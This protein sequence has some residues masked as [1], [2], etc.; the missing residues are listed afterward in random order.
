MNRELYGAIWKDD[1]AWMESMKGAKWDRLLH[2]AGAKWGNQ[3]KKVKENIPIMMHMM[4]AESEL[5]NAPFFR[6]SGKDKYAV[7]ISLLGTQSIAWNWIGNQNPSFAKDLDTCPKRYPGIVWTIEETT[8]SKGADKNCL[9]CYVK[10]YGTKPVWEKQGVGI[11]V[12]VINGRVFTTEVEHDLVQVRLVSWDATSGQDYQVHYEEKNK[13]YSLELH[14]C[15]CNI[16]YVK[17]Y[18]GPKQDLF[19]ISF[20]HKNKVCLNV[21]GGITLES[22]RFIIGDKENFLFTWE[23]ATGWRAS[24]ALIQSYQLPALKRCDNPESLLCQRGIFVTR[25]RGERTIWR[26]YK[27]KPAVFLWKGYANVTLDPWGGPWVRLQI[28]GQ[29]ALWWNSEIDERPHSGM[30]FTHQISSHQTKRGVPMVLASPITRKVKGLLI[31]GYGAYGMP[32]HFS[33]DRWAPLLHEGWAIAFGLWRG[34]GDHSPEWEDA[35]RRHGREDVL[36]DSE[37]VVRLARMITG[38]SAAKTALYGRSA[39]GLWVGGLVARYRDG[40]LFGHAY[41]E[42]PYLDVLQT[43]TNPALPLTNIEADEFGLPSQRI[44]DF[45]SILRWSPMEM[46]LQGARKPVVQ[47]IVRTGLNDKHVFAYEAAKWY[48]RCGAN[49][50]LAIEGNQGHFVSGLVGL[51]QKAEDLAVLLDWV[52]QAKA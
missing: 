10:E 48:A 22:R 16:G 46:L 47:Q 14:R 12:A 38:V 52:S 45:A 49:C 40:E 33:T 28:P 37:E 26:I 8:D 35:G 27:N 2:E 1:F 39:G 31:V 17:R 51:R 21:V 30:S 43:T 13:T 11:E 24:T 5:A 3:V 34:G 7:E 23:H 32:T 50:F 20:D 9:R 4:K 36:L 29:S 18:S 42:V 19:C 44:S 15:T 41:M 6:T 25:C